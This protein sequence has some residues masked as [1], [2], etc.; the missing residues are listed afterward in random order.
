MRQMSTRGKFSIAGIG[1]LKPVRKMEGKTLLELQLEVARQA[2]LDAGMEMSE[3]DG[4]A[5]IPSLYGAPADPALLPTLLAEYLDIDPT[6]SNLAEHAGASGCS[7]AWRAGAAIEAGAC[8]TVLC[9]GADLFE[10]SP[11]R[12]Y[13][14]GDPKYEFDMPYGPTGANSAYALIA[15]R[16]MYEYGTTSR[17]LAKVA[18]DQRTNA[19]SNP[20]AIFYGKP[21]TIADVLASPMV[22]DPL[23]MLD[24]V[25]PCSGGAS[26]VVTSAERA[27]RCP[28]PPVTLLGW[29]EKTTH[30][31]LMTAP[32]LTTSSIAY[33][34]AKAFNMAGL[35][36][37]QIN[38]A[39]VYDCY[40]ITVIVTLEDAGFCAKGTGGAFV[41]EHDLTFRG[42]L[43]LNTHGGQLSF[44]Q[45]GLS[46]GTSHVIEAIRQLRGQAGER[47]ISNC[48]Y[49]FVN[50]NGGEMGEEVSLV[51]G[52]QE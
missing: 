2:V 21:I 16:H 37:K 7:M 24:V 39:S 36:P 30:R 33:T 26:F 28:K 10:P 23:H 42:D 11:Q 3:I 48:E 8:R 32:S 14:A 47:Q 46:G 1:E 4:L 17:Q 19:C 34:S 41:E 25:M 5:V 18:V 31:S 29:G 43:P 52:R 13:R 38:L 9:V 51:F 50:G 22:A 44:G 49:A 27:R 40:T 35:T 45:P 20:N 6:Y 15:R 12:E